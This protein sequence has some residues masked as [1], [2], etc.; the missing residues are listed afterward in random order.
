VT[1]G[2]L[3]SFPLATPM[4]PGCCACRAPSDSLSPPSSRL[5]SSATALEGESRAGGSVRVMIAN[6]ALAP[7]TRR[8]R[9][10]PPRSSVALVPARRGRT[11]DARRRKILV[12]H[13]PNSRGD[14]TAYSMKNLH[15]SG[16][17]RYGRRR[18][19]WLE[20]SCD[21]RC[22]RPTAL[23]RG[24]SERGHGR[25]LITTMIDFYGAVA[26]SREV[27]RG[28]KGPSFWDRGS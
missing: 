15:W 22:Q 5:C 8:L 27:G 19:V 4:P 23:A 3:G 25:L 20:T 2:A 14:D 28:A 16:S 11:L 1:G 9:R 12:A 13:R 6:D 17:S 26:A 18:A 7:P 10:G 21:S 24:F